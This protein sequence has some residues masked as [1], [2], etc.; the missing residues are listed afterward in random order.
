VQPHASELPRLASRPKVVVR[1]N[2]AFDVF[3]AFELSLGH[4]Q[5]VS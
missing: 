3:S 1:G 4:R 5:P 2:L